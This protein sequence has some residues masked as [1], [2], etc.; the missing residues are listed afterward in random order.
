MRSFLGELK[1]ISI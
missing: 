1:W